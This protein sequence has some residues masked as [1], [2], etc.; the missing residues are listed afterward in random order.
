MNLE[1]IKNIGDI[2][3]L[4]NGE[5]IVIVKYDIVNNLIIYIFIDYVDRF[6]FV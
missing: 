6:N 4:N 2:K 3:D 5:I 1:D